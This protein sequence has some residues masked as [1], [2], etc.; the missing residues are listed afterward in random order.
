M[1]AIFMPA[2]IIAGL[3]LI[4]GIV[5]SIASIL[6]SIPVNEKEQAIKDILPGAN[7][8]ACGFPGCDGFAVAVASGEADITGCPPGGSA[9]RDALSALM[10]VEAG[11]VRRL[12]A[13]VK[14]NGC[15]Q[16]TREKMRYM[17]AGSCVCANQM[18]GGQLACSYGCLGFAD[19]MTV[20]AYDAIRI[21]NGLAVVD[22]DLCAGCIL[23]VAACPKG[24]IQMIPATDAAVILC[25][26]HDRGA[27]VR[28]ACRVGC[29]GCNLCKKACP[30]GAIA[31]E[32]YLAEIDY[33][34]CDGCGKCAAVCPQKAIGMAGA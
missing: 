23:C 22:S 18:Y 33:Q 12:S 3:G 11:A 8:G 15:T 7:C 9:L 4:C 24:L 16:N 34:A 10:G 27:V 28:K 29:I 30:Q 26:S 19:C 32:G 31:I 2:L 5:I 13:Q 6:M 25:S 1:T 20:C 17:G 14:C 21:V